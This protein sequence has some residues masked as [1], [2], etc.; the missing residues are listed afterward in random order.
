M[1]VIDGERSVKA[2][3]KKSKA[4]TSGHKWKLF[5]LML[6]MIPLNLLGFLALGVGVIVTASISLIAMVH[7]YEFLLKKA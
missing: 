2:A 4:L 1:I 7:A 3:L 6:V 5:L